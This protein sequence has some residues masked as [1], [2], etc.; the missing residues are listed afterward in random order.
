MSGRSATPDAGKPRPVVR[1]RSLSSAADR[2]DDVRLRT[3]VVAEI[4]K[5][6]GEQEDDIRTAVENGVVILTGSI[7]SARIRSTLDAVIAR[8]PGVRG[9]VQ[10]L[11]VVWPVKIQRTPTEIVL[12]A[13]AAAKKEMPDDSGNFVVIFENGWLRLE[14]TVRVSARQRLISSLQHISGSRGVIDMLTELPD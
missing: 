4:S 7:S 6:A 10:E 8:V 12:E 9:I 5:A 2:D 11:D 14:G 13:L 1:G 3:A